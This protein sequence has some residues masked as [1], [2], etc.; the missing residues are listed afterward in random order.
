MKT[1][2]QDIGKSEKIKEYEMTECHKI[3]PKRG[4]YSILDLK[5]LKLDSYENK[6]MTKVDVM[7]IL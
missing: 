7:L 5:A 2:F 1:L 3:N 4:K 6:K